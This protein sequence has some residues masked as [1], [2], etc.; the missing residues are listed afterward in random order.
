M[1]DSAGIEIASA[2]ATAVR[3]RARELWSHP[4]RNRVVYGAWLVVLLIVIHLDLR[5]CIGL[6]LFIGLMILHALQVRGRHAFQA[7]ERP[8]EKGGP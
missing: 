7:L 4:T 2:V 8:G 1:S 6:P 5:D 3:R